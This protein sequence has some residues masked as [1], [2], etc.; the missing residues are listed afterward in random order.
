MC[1]SFHSRVISEKIVSNFGHRVEEIANHM[2][3]KFL[4]K[5]QGVTMSRTRASRIRQL[6][7]SFK[8]S[9]SFLFHE[10]LEIL[11][12]TFQ[13]KCRK[14]LERDFRKEGKLLDASKERILNELIIDFEKQARSLDVPLFGLLSKK[15]IDDV[16]SMLQ[17]S[18]EEFPESAVAKLISLQVLDKNIQARNRQKKKGSRG[19]LPSFTI[20][21]LLRPP[22]YSNFQG[23]LTLASSMMGFPLDVLLGVQN[24]GDS[25]EV[26]PFCYFFYSCD[27]VFVFVFML[28]FRFWGPIEN[29]HC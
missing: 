27:P 3:K 7:D 11:Q 25:L 5:T 1:G 10:Q 14:L 19:I 8:L 22:G 15:K 6:F 4:E 2:Q 21:G 16:K 24:D 12:R 18:I 9:V 26:C 28:I 17:T 20:V 23:Y 13:Q 29:S